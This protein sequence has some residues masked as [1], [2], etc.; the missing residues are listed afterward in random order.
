MEKCNLEGVLRPGTEI[1][2]LLGHKN[3]LSWVS[4]HWVVWGLEIEGWE[5]GESI[6]GHL[7]LSPFGFLFISPY[8][9]AFMIMYSFW[10]CRFY[11]NMSS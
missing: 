4:W 1:G 5:V 7:K 9:Y 10:G 3:T 11:L 8:L 6:E 2:Q